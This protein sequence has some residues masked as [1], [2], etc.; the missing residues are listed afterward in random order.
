M[1][2]WL[3]Q[4]IGIPDSWEGV[5]QSTASECTLSAILSAREKY[6]EFE[7]NRRGLSNQGEIPSIWFFP[8]PFF[9]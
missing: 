2:N 1:M 3:G 6:S 5:I 7:V 8:N 4:L 9:H